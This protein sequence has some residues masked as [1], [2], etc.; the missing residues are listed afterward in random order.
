MS[1]C[2]ELAKAVLTAVELSLTVGA[3]TKSHELNVLN[4]LVNSILAAISRL[5][6][7]PLCA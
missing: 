4:R 1:S 5:R 7:P 3:P 2:R 6:A